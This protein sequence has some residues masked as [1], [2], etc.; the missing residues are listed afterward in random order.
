MSGILGEPLR[1]A[2]NTETI[3]KITMSD[4]IKHHKLYEFFKGLVCLIL[5]LIV[6]DGP[7][8]DKTSRASV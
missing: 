1:L 7:E 8:E 6:N 5:L 3:R 2:K 4:I